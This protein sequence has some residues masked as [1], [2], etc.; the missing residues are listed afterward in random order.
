[1][2]EGARCSW[3]RRAQPEIPGGKFFFADVHCATWNG[4]TDTVEL[5]LLKGALIEARNSS[6]E[7][8]LYCATWKDHTDTA[9]LLFSKGASMVARNIK[10][11][12]P[13][14]IPMFPGVTGAPNQYPQVLRQ[15]RPILQ[16]YLT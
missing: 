1:M 7:T 12:T 13:L 15:G 9:E 6:Q 14:T 16:Y 2:R 5:L 10:G 8:P 3:A 4:H 11:W